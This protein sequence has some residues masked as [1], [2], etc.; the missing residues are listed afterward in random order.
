MCCLD[1]AGVVGHPSITFFDSPESA[2]SR[3]FEKLTTGYP[4]IQE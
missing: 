4:V 1:S 2:A 3:E